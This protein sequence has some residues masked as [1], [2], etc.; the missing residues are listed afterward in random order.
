MSRPDL[1]AISE[2]LTTAALS[3][4]AAALEI[5]GTAGFRDPESALRNLQDLARPEG[6]LPLPAASLGELLDV[7]DPDMAL[8]NLER[9][10]GAA[11]GRSSFLRYLVHHPETCRVIFTV[12]GSSQFLSDILVRG[13]E[14]AYWLTDPPDRLTRP[15]IKAELYG[16]FSQELAVFRTLEARLNALRRLHRRELLRIGSGDLV[17]NRPI[18]RVA[19]ELSDL[20][21]VCLQQLLDLLLPELHA[22]YGPPMD[23]D[24]SPAE[25]S[26]IG[27]GKLGGRELNFS[28]DI[29]LVFL[30]SE[31]GETRGGGSEGGRTPNQ[32]Y[33]SR[34]AER[35][36]KEA[37]E[38][39]EEGFL[40]R[41]DTRLRPD[42]SAGVLAM[43]L[44]GYENYYAQRGELW[45]RQML[46]K[47][48]ICA[49]SE[50]LGRRFLERLQP[51]VYPGHFDVSP[52]DEI[53]R[54]K[55]RIED[56][57]GRSGKRETHLKLR[58]GGIRDVEFIV[59]CL[60]LLVGRVHKE[61]RSG[62]TLTALDQ[63]EGASALSREEAHALR[64]AYVFFR[65]V[66]HRLQMLHGLSDHNLP[67]SE[68]RLV[69]LAR[70]LAFDT[71]GEYDD[72]LGR[73]LS[74]VRMIFQSVFSEERDRGS[75][76]VA[77]LCEMD[78]GDPEAE[79]LL[80]E[81]GFV[82]PEEAHR[83]LVFLAY[84]H[85]PRAQ[86]T[87]A[88]NSFLELAPELVQAVQGSADPDL[89]L[90]NF[91]RLI[92]A[93]G[94]A[95]T[96]YRILAGHRG[97]R[98]LLIAICA[99]SEYLVN[100]LVR[101]PALLDWLTL[102][103]VL[104]RD[105]TPEELGQELRR[106]TGETT[107]QD[108]RLA[109]LNAF[110]NREL[111]RIGTRDMVGLTDSFETF[112]ALSL[113]AEVVLRA[114]HDSAYMGLTSRRG[115][116]RTQ[117]G[118]VAQFAV[119]GLGKLGGRELS[120]GS[121]LDLVFVYSDEGTTDGPE[122][123]GNQQFFIDLA[124]QLIN[125]LGQSTPHGTLYP[126]D[127]R[128]RPEGGSAMLALSYDAYDGYFTRRAGTW[129]RLALSR[130]RLVAG[131][132]DFGRRLLDR[133]ERFV[134]GEGLSD[135]DRE[136]LVDVR[137]R[138]E[139]QSHRQPTTSL[140]TGRGGIVDIEFIVQCL[141]IRHGHTTPSVRH[142]NTLAS[143]DRLEKEGCLPRGQAESLRSALLFLRTAEKVLRRHD[144]RARTRLPADDRALA[145]LARATGFE[146]S[147][148]FQG[149]LAEA[150]DRTRGLFETYVGK[151]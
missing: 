51:F 78:A 26:V 45:E 114:V 90:S 84:G 71:L 58:A 148:A 10:V 144:E 100:L 131:D 75:R 99:G 149:S 6:A 46:I 91:E 43:S 147:D 34:L 121:D 113:L 130:C 9:L 93:Y 22:R 141:Q 50:R 73:H 56:H 53:R 107:A 139:E 24:G 31:D 55:R 106:A 61:A 66:E 116:P 69:P 47:A 42:G 65:R 16:A 95:D 89:A 109:A 74:A 39:T 40:Y 94:A 79:R 17:A 77:A 118:E 101:N 145:A 104:Y 83:N 49:G 136:A 85:A 128:L 21:D 67:E 87:R 12:L 1:E 27:L 115:L 76:P 33:Y 70:S 11:F 80:G 59:Q 68:E 150:M 132:E 102:P 137:R 41:V 38:P 4:P 18:Q 146:D 35:L 135:S 2:R 44:P 92:S 14:L 98:D 105:R 110:K 140:K 29:D 133:I 81:W 32:V 129:E 7:P 3:D 25:F 124:Q 125:G 86:G 19:Q 20:A 28:S 48:R 8:N 151:P 112:E 64:A 62:N 63:L 57:I 123:V 30:Y 111:L 126:V 52:T 134:L 119:L 60:Q 15:S 142:P 138:M 54:I 72:A 122:P 127:A 96:L 103:D 23:P 88:R 97:L 143:L 120:F 36:L 5:L 108:A 13:P 117:T 82:L 37:T